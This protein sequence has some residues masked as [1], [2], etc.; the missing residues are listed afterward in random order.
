MINICMYNSIIINVEGITY[1][2]IYIKYSGNTK[3]KLSLKIILIC[4]TCIIS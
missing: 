1:N 4:I 2:I 3:L